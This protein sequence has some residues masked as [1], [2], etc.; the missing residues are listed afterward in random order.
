MKKVHLNINQFIPPVLTVVFLLLGVILYQKMTGQNVIGTSTMPGTFTVDATGEVEAVPNSHTTTYTINEE[1]TT[2][3]E[4][5]EKGNLKQTNAR[6]VLKELGFED[7]DIKTD[8]YYINPNYEIL[9]A[10][11]SRESGFQINITTT[12]KSKD[13][14]KINKAIDELVAIGVQVGG[15]SSDFDSTNNEELK[16]K[17]REKAIISAKQ[18]AEQLASAAGFKIGKIAS[19]YESVPYSSGPM[20]MFAEKSAVALDAGA[21]TQIDPGSDKLSVQVTITYYIKD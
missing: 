6:E 15:V 19:I 4:A 20:P 10:G 13:L 3:K 14:D 2:E 17:A 7:K 12:V 9:P 18:K 16:A 11:G 1:G 8:G 5:Q 21:P